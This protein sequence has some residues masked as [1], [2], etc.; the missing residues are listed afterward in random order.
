MF[1]S[2]HG[3]GFVV[4]RFLARNPGHRWDPS[5][6]MIDLSADAFEFGDYET[7]YYDS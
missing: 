1:S 5:L 7:M 6:G 4:L 3:P 2:R